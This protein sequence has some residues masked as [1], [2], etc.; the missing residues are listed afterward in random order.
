MDNSHEPV[1]NFNENNCGCHGRAPMRFTGGEA[2]VEAEGQV[3]GQ[4][5][6]GGDPVTCGNGARGP[7]QLNAEKQV[8]NPA[9]DV[10]IGTFPDIIQSETSL[11]RFKDFILYGFNDLADVSS[12][13][14]AFS[15][16]LGRTWSD[17]GSIPLNQNGANNGD[18]TLAVD[19]NGVFY[20]GQIGFEVLGGVRQSV[21]SVSTG[22]VN[23]NRTITM[24]QPQA[25][26]VAP[27][28]VTPNIFTQDKPW[29]AVGPDK[30][31]P[32]SEALYAAWVDFSNPGGGTKIR[33]SKHRTGINL[34][35]LIQSK[36]II[37]GTNEV[38][39]PF[40]VVDKK[41][42]I[43][44][45][46]ESRLPGSFTTVTGPT[47]QIRMAK[48]TDGGNTFPT[49]IQVSAGLFEAA[50]NAVAAC[51]GGNNR[52]VIRVTAQQTIRMFEIPQAA[53]GDDGTIYV[54]WNAGRTVGGIKRIDIFL[55]FS[56][57]AG[58]TWQ[59]VNLTEN[60]TSFAFFPSVAVNKNG[61]HVQY[62]RFN[63]PNRVGGVGNGNF[64]VFM[65][66]FS[67]LKDISKERM[68]STKFSPVAVFLCYMGEYN[69]VI[70]GP[71]ESL[72][73]AWSDNRNVLNGQNNP[74]V[75]F[76]QT[77]TMLKPGKGPHPLHP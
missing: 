71:R 55:A 43:Y 14:F 15:S 24:N 57:D 5:Q 48:S 27:S 2:E 18:P 49:D 69:Q 50:A 61:A 30:N 46:Y 60:E 7:G 77:T 13:G 21:I 45:F 9:K 68:I 37:S 20:Y 73:H 59:Q 36:T 25:I 74:D 64:A 47:R 42:N 22:K 39:G 56:R 11:A 34:V 75:F 31:N 52:P 23:P 32:G 4:G 41:G 19:R 76:I 8:N 58:Q 70:N 35:P 62:N 63:D 29:I 65:K 44:V 51:E 72:L 12:S 33:F 10:A 26:G 54:V 38:F 53:I 3:Q 1:S 16:D 28:P 67:R 40:V 66:T 17:C 6:G